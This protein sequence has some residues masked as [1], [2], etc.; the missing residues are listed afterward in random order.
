M[1]RNEC[2][3][4]YYRNDS[5]QDN[6]EKISQDKRPWEEEDNQTDLNSKRNRTELLN[7][8]SSSR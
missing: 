2:F 6:G 1:L 5:E 3:L 4:F 8:P 7:E